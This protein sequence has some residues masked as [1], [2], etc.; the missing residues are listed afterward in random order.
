MYVCVFVCVCTYVCMYVCVCMYVGMCVC[1]CMCVCTYVCLYV[2]VYIYILNYVNLT[3]T[4]TLVARQVFLVVTENDQVDRHITKHDLVSCSLGRE[5][6]IRNQKGQPDRRTSSSRL[7]GTWKGPHIPRVRL[8]Q[9]Q[10]GQQYSRHYGT[11]KC[12]CSVLYLMTHTCFTTKYSML[13]PVAVRTM[14]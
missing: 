2:Y 3:K 12:S 6:G 7:T 1:V 9:Y 5:G 4:K 8:H 10:T 14:M 13:R 11:A